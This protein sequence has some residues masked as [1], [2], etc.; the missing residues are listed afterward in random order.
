MKLVQKLKEWNV[1]D[2]RT[3]PAR[4][5]ITYLA[6]VLQLWLLH[7]Q[8]IMYRNSGNMLLFHSWWKEISAN[9]LIQ[10]VL[11]FIHTRGKLT[12]PA[13]TGGFKACLA[14]LGFSRF[15]VQQMQDLADLGFSRFR[16]QQ[17]Q[18]LADLGFSRFRVQGLY[19]RSE[20]IKTFIFKVLT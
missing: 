5:K 20:P 9:Q 8:L 2:Q 3:K 4:R 11:G 15:R 17:I 1:D 7:F 6:C 18:G 16:V 19:Y 12:K 13:Y 10:E 14:D